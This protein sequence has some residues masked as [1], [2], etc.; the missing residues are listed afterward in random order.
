MLAAALNKGEMDPEADYVARLRE[1]VDI[2][3]AWLGEEIDED[4]RAGLEYE[5]GIAEPLLE[6]ENLTNDKAYV[7]NE[8]LALA[9]AAAEATPVSGDYADT[10]APGLT[11]FFGWEGDQYAPIAW[12]DGTYQLRNNKNALVTFGVTNLPDNS[13]RWSRAEGYLPCLIS[14]YSKN[15]LDHTVESFADEVIIGGRR[16][17]TAYSRM[18][19]YN[20]TGEVKLLPRVSENLVPLNDAAKSAKVAQSGETVVREYCIFA[21]RFGGKYTFPGNDVLAE[22][23]SYEEHYAHMKDHWDGRVAELADI[24]SVPEPYAELTHVYKAGYIDML[25]AADGE[26]F[27]AGE[28]TDNDE[29]LSD[30]DGLGMLTALAQLGHTEG[31]ADYARAVMEKTTSPDVFWQFSWPFAV[32]LQKTGDCLTVADFFEDQGKYDGIKSSTHKI[33]QDRVIVDGSVVA[34]GSPAKI[35]KQTDSLG[36]IG[37]WTADNFAALHGL[38]TYRYL[39]EQLFA[40]T[41]EGKYAAERDWA[42]AEYENL[43]KSVEGVLESTMLSEALI[44]IPKSMVE[45]NGQDDG[46]GSWVALYLPGQWSWDGYLFGAEQ[47]SPLLELTDATYAAVL[48][49][50]GDTP[51][52]LGGGSGFSTSR[53]AGYFSGALGGE[54]YRAYGIE[55]CKWM[56]DN[57]MSTPYGW[58]ENP[59]EPTGDALWEGS[60]PLGG[61]GGCPHVS[62]QIAN[63]Q[64]LLDAFL[65]ER[66]DGTLIAGRGLPTAFNAPGER[67]QIDNYLCNSGQRIGYTMESTEKMIDFT[68]TGDRPEHPVSLELPVLKDNIA[69][70]S[71]NCTFDSGSGTVILPVGTTSVTIGLKA[72]GDIITPVIDAIDAIGEVTTGSGAA[73][74]GARAKYDALTDEQKAL[75]SNY[76]KLVDAEKAYQDLLN[77]PSTG[78]SSSSGRPS[79]TPKTKTETNA[80]GSK[81]TT[82]TDAKGNV[83]QTTEYAE[84]TRRVRVTGTDGIVT[85][86]VTRPDGSE[87]KTVILPGESCTITVKTAGGKT[88]AR[89]EIPAE[90]PA[91]KMFEDI[92]AEHWARKGV[93][94]VSALGL[95]EGTSERTFTGDAGMTRGMI[96][97]VLHRLSGSVEAEQSGQFSD[98]SGG[99]WYAGAV[100]WAAEHGIVQGVGSGLFAPEEEISREM[101]ITI[102]CRYAALLGLDTNTQRDALAPF[103]DSVQVSAWAESSVA[104]AVEKG[105]ISGGSGA[106]RP[107]DTAT[108]AE[109]A[110]ILTGF[111]DLLSK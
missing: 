63:A 6:D 107:G 76:Q 95:F 38:T 69:Y 48:R 81:T 62:G 100:D 70:V 101:L 105:L 78:G 84:G 104:W 1:S 44:A 3:N 93:D 90:L 35:M 15:G 87:V 102:L 55:A 64:M 46:D 42:D 16:Y 58:W 68:L 19:T 11:G 59:A 67:V 79:T 75:V 109:V 89:V 2:A 106:L 88:A 72:A 82:V 52:N 80:D 28:G 17:E 65:A 73:I 86:T 5:L 51:F 45:P 99:A 47:D 56:I 92:G 41:G 8:F 94:M 50:L 30:R 14:Q 71:G 60:H 54:L 43:L 49:Q 108:R 22:Q 7:A 74:E 66:A 20:D 96:V 27:R 77:R 110:V 29:E 32:Y 37:Y 61:T 12:A 97:T 39:C 23:G 33:A 57:T 25:I 36:S 91:A 111:I 53:N 40:E 10:Y 26:Q 24:Q 21:D 31:F 18:T 98:V 9:L 103:T 4:V 83:T 34:D 13:I 85:Q